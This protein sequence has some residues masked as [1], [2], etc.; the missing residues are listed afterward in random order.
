MIQLYD[1]LKESIKLVSLKEKNQKFRLVS[2]KRLF[3][4]I[5]PHWKKGLYGSIFM[6]ALSLL[7]LPSPYLMKLIFDKVL[8]AR[9]IRL[10]NL[11]IILLLG[12]Q[13]IRVIFSILTDYHFNLFSQEIMVKVKKDLFYRILRLPLCFF[14]KNQTGYILS[15]IGEAEGLNFFFSSTLTRILISFFEFVFCLTILFYLNW[16]LTL[17]SLAILPIFYFATKFYSRGIRRL[18]R[19]TYERG[20]AI[21]RQIQ[22]SLSG[23][24]VIKSFSAEKRE[25]EKIH[26]YLDEF[27]TINIKRN[28]IFSF[29][30][31]M[32]SLLGV[33]GGFVVLWYS[34]L[35]IIKGSFTVGSYIA[36]SAYVGK[37]Y[38]PTQMVAN[39]G[40]TFQSAAIALDR[41]SELMDLA[42]EE[43][44]DHG[45]N[46]KS[47]NRKIEFKNVYFS[48]DNKQ[49]LSDINIRIKKGEKVILAGPNGSGKST[50]VKLILGLYKAQN[51]SILVD[52]HDI[53]ELSLSSLREKISIVSQ[54]TF[55]FNDTIRNNILYSRPEAKEEEIEE[56]ARLSGAYE[57][58]RELERGFETEIGERGVRLSGGER[59]K[60]SIARTILKNSDIIIFD[61]ATAHLDEGSEKR[62]N[63]LIWDKFKDKTCIII[64]QRVQ[65]MPQVDKVYYLKKGKIA[66]E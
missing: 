10:L 37:L 55:L 5:K 28:I 42:G 17:I 59:Q 56:A 9:N 44:S 27:K 36:F 8:V 54:N 50:I 39:I 45:I 58:I 65:S 11:I 34:G 1:Y 49:V 66:N 32:L 15:R 63:A 21:S 62:T 4:Y 43:E 20:A 61:E 23:V 64:S 26:T 33:L 51:G 13:L 16:K 38:G 53:T 48:Y 46:I 29:S 25:T 35:D 18:A 7:A 60:I 24:D 31:E 30:S 57:F 22:D 19:E 2:L 40:I 3:P 47:V 12:I 14:D 52:D 41:I 6:I